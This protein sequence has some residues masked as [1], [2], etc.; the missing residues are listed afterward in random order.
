MWLG[1]P[2]ERPRDKLIAIFDEKNLNFFRQLKFF[3]FMAIKTLDPS[4]HPG[5]H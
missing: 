5:Q 1:R 3:P 2:L 4:P